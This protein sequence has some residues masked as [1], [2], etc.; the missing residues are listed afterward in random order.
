ARLWVNKITLEAADGAAAPGSPIVISSA[1]S[2]V[3]G[4]GVDSNLEAL[5][6]DGS[7]LPEGSVISLQNIDFAVVVGDGLVVQGGEGSNIY[8]GDAGAQSFL[9]GDDDDLIHAGG[10]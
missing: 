7:Q 2:K 3:S 10:G 9:M 1:V 6:I 4:D 5:V 8:Y